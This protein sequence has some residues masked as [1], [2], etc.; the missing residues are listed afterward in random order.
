MRPKLSA[1]LLAVAV[2]LCGV[3]SADK[4][5]KPG[6]RHGNSND[7]GVGTSS[8]QGRPEE[9]AEATLLERFYRKNFLRDDSGEKSIR[10]AF[11]AAKTEFCDWKKSPVSFLK[12]EVCGKYYKVLELNRNDRGVDS[13]ERKIKRAYRSKS[14]AL[15]PD[16][17]IESGAS[18][19]FKLI[20]EA[21]E[22]LSDKR[23]KQ[24]Y[25]ANLA[26]MEQ[27]VADW[28]RQLRATIKNQ[29]YHGVSEA[30]Y[31]ASLFAQNFYQCK[32]SC[33]CI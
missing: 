8:T 31:Y 32:T 1:L 22:C 2:L 15:H 27:E 29:L 25:D 28:R 11:E 12:G 10:A 19:A 24:S 5:R 20:R 3:L 14:L 6:G 7:T 30:H 9:A 4:N 16:K 26:A 23:C 18:D 21:Y 33:L 17:N 13:I